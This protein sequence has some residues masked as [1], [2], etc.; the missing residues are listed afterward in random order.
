MLDRNPEY[1]STISKKPETSKDLAKDEGFTKLQEHK[2]E[3]I[4][5]LFAYFEED[6]DRLIKNHLQF[7]PV[8]TKYLVRIKTEKAHLVQDDHE[9][10]DVTLTSRLEGPNDNQTGGIKFEEFFVQNEFYRF[11]LVEAF[12]YYLSKGFKNLPLKD[13]LLDPPLLSLLR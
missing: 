4:Q 6:H 5:E 2:L 11:L 9:D 1:Y 8:D 10:R 13:L 12:A 7:Y 3:M